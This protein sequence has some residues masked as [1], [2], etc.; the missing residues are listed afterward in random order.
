MLF[1][2]LK[3]ALTAIRRNVLRS[4]LTLLGVTIG[5]GAVIAMVTLGQGTTLSVNNSI[6]GLGSNLL[7]VQP[8]QMGQGG[9]SGG[10]C[11][12][13]HR[14]R[15][16]DRTAGR[17]HCGG[18]RRPSVR[19]LTA[20][21]GPVNH[22][23]EVAGVDNGFF[24]VRQR[25]VAS[26]RMFSEG[27][28]VSGAA[29]CILGKATADALFGTA[30]AARP[31]PAA[32]EAQLQGD[33]R[34]ASKRARAGSGTN[35]DDVILIPLHTFQRRISGSN[36]VSVISARR[37]ERGGDPAKCRTTSPRCCASAGT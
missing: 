35:Q 28:L 34:A 36:D 4:V 33:R 5:V 31:E 17:G 27:E 30:D 22:F 21:A 24:A 18:L 12:L 19:S 15:R 13:P 37:R 20:V 3:L 8:G 14:R 16:G 9:S 7:I 26:G 23:V 2:T 10:G 25:P 11:G 32:Q 1:E 29:V 6:S